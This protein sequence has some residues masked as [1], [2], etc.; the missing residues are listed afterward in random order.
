MLDNVS[1][2]D[3]AGGDPPGDIQQQ[4]QEALTQ[5][6]MKKMEVVEP[7]APP[8]SSPAPIG[9]PFM[10][11]SSGATSSV[12]PVSD[13]SG[14]DASPS[15]PNPTDPLTQPS[16]TPMD[17][18]VPMGT[19]E[20]GVPRPLTP[21]EDQAAVEEAASAPQPSADAPSPEISSVSGVAE[22][23]TQ[24][25][26]DDAKSSDTTDESPSAPMEPPSLPDPA[27]V[28]STSDDS[29]VATD[30]SPDASGDESQ[31]DESSESDENKT[32]DRESS[33]VD[34]DTD[35]NEE[36]SGTSTVPAVDTD[37]LA[38]MKQHALDHLEPLA[39]GLDQSPEE[40]FRTTIMRIQANDNHTLLEKAL[41]AAKR[42]EDDEARAKALLDII[43]EI[44][45][46]SQ[47]S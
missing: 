16:P 12:P 25:D 46:F 10:V 29:D 3:F 33:E 1:S 14:A 17:A 38:A 8:A 24:S 28:A 37:K 4:V 36:S 9:S 2:R 7:V 20:S 31:S 21:E 47:K 40:E 26:S 18:S 35:K 41:E 23:S 44:N 19:D 43:N 45:Y 30:E 32:S 5:H 42:I 34:E 22:T 6:E 11:S 15:L 39:D 13:T 27:V